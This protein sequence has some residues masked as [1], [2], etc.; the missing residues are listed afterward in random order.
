MAKPS[1][2]R[3]AILG[4]AALAGAGVVVALSLGSSED[5][6]QAATTATVAAPL[7]G[8]PLVALPPVDGLT[9]GDRLGQL[10]ALAAKDPTRAD[11]QMAIGSE[12]L[13]RGDGD[14]ATAAF[15]AARRLGDPAADVA[16][17]VRRLR[18]E[19]AGRH[20]RAAEAARAQPAVRGIRARCRAAL[21]RTP[22]LASAAL[23][24]V[25]DT[26][27]ETFYGVRADD[28]L[29]PT[30][31]A[32]YPLFVPAE[33][34]PAGATATTL[35]T[36]ARANPDDAVAQLQYGASLQAAGRRS[37]AIAAYRRA[38]KADPTSIEAQ[39]ALAVGG[40]RRTIRRRRSAPSVPWHAI[41]RAIRHPAS[42][43]R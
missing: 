11:L 31:Q 20:R 4:V 36:A 23:K 14:A 28:L 40:F 35:A 34:P 18:P 3:L 22:A 33:D 8:L 26:A 6:P 2:Q 21:G 7:S 43:S 39:V 25:R 24:A 9:A 16:L 42:T 12:Q 5:P 38:V 19:A 41:T 27:P 15:T 29:H 13:V 30:M 37:E 1:R 32:G 10:Q 17:A